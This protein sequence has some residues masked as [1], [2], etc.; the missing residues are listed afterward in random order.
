MISVCLLQTAFG[1]PARCG[2]LCTV[3]LPCADNTIHASFCV[4]RSWC[5][6]K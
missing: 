4:Q 5:V 3:G 1:I 2:F 6:L